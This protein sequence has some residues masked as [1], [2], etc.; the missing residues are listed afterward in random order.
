MTGEGGGDAQVNLPSPTPG[1]GETE[2]QLPT[3]VTASKL[4][5]A[6]FL[7][8]SL[9]PSGPLKPISGSPPFCRSPANRASV[10]LELDHDHPVL[11]LL[12]L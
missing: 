9:C 8:A 3:A 12:Y 4:A 10:R 11:F 1:P 5:L 6:S 2:S 7:T